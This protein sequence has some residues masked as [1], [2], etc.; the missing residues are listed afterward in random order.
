MGSIVYVLGW[1]NESN[2]WA[3]VP[4]REPQEDEV[5]LPGVHRLPGQP[6]WQTLEEAQAVALVHNQREAEDLAYC[7]MVADE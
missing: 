1:D 3:A 6:C 2:Q 7:R 4:V 5:L